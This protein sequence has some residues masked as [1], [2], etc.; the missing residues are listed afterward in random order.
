MDFTIYF[1]GSLRRGPRSLC[2]NDNRARRGIIFKLSFVVYRNRNRN[3]NKFIN[4]IRAP[5]G[6]IQITIII[7]TQQ[8]YK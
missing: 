2:I 1:C 4:E 5:G 7:D 6:L 8:Q 3:R